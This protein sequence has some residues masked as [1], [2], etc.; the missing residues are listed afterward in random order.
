VCILNLHAL[1]QNV[2]GISRN[3]L[4]AH[5]FQ[6]STLSRDG[7][8]WKM[9]YLLSGQEKWQIYCVTHAINSYE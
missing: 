6:A 9:A 2:L 5:Y 8:T 3:A 4:F 1:L 7:P